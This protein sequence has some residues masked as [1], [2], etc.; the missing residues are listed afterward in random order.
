MYIFQ[1]KYALQTVYRVPICPRVSLSHFW[2][3]PISYNR[4]QGCPI[5]SLYCMYNWHKI[6]QGL[7]R[8]VTT[9]EEAI[10]LL[11]FTPDK[12]LNRA[13]FAERWHKVPLQGQSRSAV[14][15]S[16]TMRQIMKKESCSFG[17]SFVR[18]DIESCWLSMTWLAYRPT[19]Q[20]RTDGRTESVF[21]MAGDQRRSVVV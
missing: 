10:L 1:I 4:L 13:S 20:L 16:R 3:Y 9:A 21:S 5:N 17:P 19:R 2:I 18:V 14:W 15:R 12:A 7:K 6:Q 8:S 11:K